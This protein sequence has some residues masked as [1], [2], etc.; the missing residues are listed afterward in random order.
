M[1][2]ASTTMKQEERL[3]AERAWNELVLWAPPAILVVAGWRNRWVAD[4]AF[5]DLRIVQNLLHG[6]GPVFNAGER[7]EAYTSPLWVA[8]LALLGGASR[9]FPGKP[10]SLEW[11][12]VMLGL[13]FSFAA[14]ACGGHAGQRLWERVSQGT[15]PGASPRSS[16]AGWL[17]PFGMLVIATIAPF[18]DFATSGLECGLVLAWLGLSFLGSTWLDQSSPLRTRL[19]LALLFGAG[20]LVRPDLTIAAAIWIGLLV[21]FT[22]GW[23]TRAACLAVAACLPAT[24]EIFRMGYFAAVVPN[25]AIAKEASL[26][27]WPQGIAYLR[28]FIEPYKLGLGLALFAGAFAVLCERLLARGQRRTVLIAAAP[29][30]AGLLQALFVVRV[31]G[32]FMHSRML[33][34]PLFALALPV[35][36]MVTDDTVSMAIGGLAVGYAAACLLLLRVPYDR[37]AKG[38]KGWIGNERVIYVTGAKNPNPVDLDDYRSASWAANGRKMAKAAE[39]LAKSR[40]PGE[41]KFSNGFKSEPRAAHLPEGAIA[42]LVAF[43]ANVGEFSFAAGPLVYVCDPHGLPD[44]IGARLR[45]ETRAQPGHEKWAGEEWCIARKLAD[46]DAGGASE[47]KVAAARAAL[48]CGELAELLRAVGEPLSVRRFLSNLL[49][50]P[51]LSRLRFS[52][53]AEVAERELCGGFERAPS[54]NGGR[55]PGSLPHAACPRTCPGEKRLR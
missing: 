28:D 52:A 21:A 23:R 7:V 8:I 25:T 32:D 24:Y 39:D 43:R 30:L 19:A 15:A 11:T 5:I 10:I 55:G 29:V 3:S 54:R 2:P 45:L 6:L 38:S 46:N 14:L 49:E 47:S 40:E 9:L 50:A 12:A 27:Y 31:G 36:V 53:N 41:G 34:P 1:V 48:G 20:P 18:W 16:T 26:S 33:L 42:T 17:T 13:A 37:W 4:D 51:R 35:A 44:P 22:E